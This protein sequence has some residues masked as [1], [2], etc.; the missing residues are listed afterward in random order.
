MKVALIK[1]FQ[2]IEIVPTNNFRFLNI[3]LESNR[4]CPENEMQ[5]H[6]WN[7]D[8]D[9]RF[10]SSV[11]WGEGIKNQKEKHI[12]SFREDNIEINV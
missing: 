10:F 2:N 12:Y 7:Q 4:I 9:I 11:N 5:L 3:S 1:V 6:I 8:F